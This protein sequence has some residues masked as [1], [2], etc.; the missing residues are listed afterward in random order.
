MFAHLLAIIYGIANIIAAF[1]ILFIFP[2]PSAIKLFLVFILLFKGIPS[3][4]GDF[5]CKIDGMVDVTAALAIAG[6]FII[7]SP[8]NIIMALMLAW[9][10]L[11]SF[12]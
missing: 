6:F 7:P 5:L 3:F 1:Y 2:L 11:L 10:A 4:A 12:F 9:V 8:V